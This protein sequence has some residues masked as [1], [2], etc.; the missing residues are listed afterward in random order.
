[1]YSRYKITMMKHLNN[2]TPFN[3]ILLDIYFKK[4]AFVFNVYINLK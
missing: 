3:K 1:M 4:M 2:A